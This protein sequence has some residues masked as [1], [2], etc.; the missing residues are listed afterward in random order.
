MRNETSL[1]TFSCEK[2]TGVTAGI[3]VKITKMIERKAGQP[4]NITR[5]E[6]TEELL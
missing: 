6:Q 5:E 4:G 1:E 2:Q 3:E